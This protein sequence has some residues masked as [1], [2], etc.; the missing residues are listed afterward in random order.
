MEEKVLTK[1]RQHFNEF[2]Q[3]IEYAFILEQA[4]A[5]KLNLLFTGIPENER[6]PD[7]A[8]IRNICSSVLKIN[9]LSIASAQRIGVRSASAGRP[10][11]I[12]ARF[13]SMPDRSR[14][15]QA[16][17]LLQHSPGGKIWMQ[18]DMPKTLK[19]DLR[20][21]LMVAKHAS[22]IDKEEYKSIKV[23]DFCLH[24][25]GK[26]YCPVELE[27]LPYGS[28]PSTFC[29]TWSD[30][31][32]AFFGRFSPLSNPHMSPFIINDTKFQSVEQ[33]LAVARARLSGDAELL[34]RALSCS[35]PADCKGI[36]NALRDDHTQEWEE[37]RAP[38][39]MK[40]LRGKFNQN[41]HLGT[42]LKNTY[43]RRLGEASRDIVWGIGLELKDR[44][45]TQHSAWHPGG[46]L[47]GRLLMTVRDELM[48]NSDPT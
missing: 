41:G 21:L 44:D 3:Q 12:L 10:R 5:R 37:S 14:V 30:E 18:E 28:H 11:P 15:W 33:F 16:K 26:S 40:A 7:I 27:T 34:E 47:L 2:S 9:K 6:V 43:P 39:L 19:E 45:V 42:Y 22:T 48:R 35:N 31:A 25:N 1:T 38:V 20:V 36:L 17:N 8:K 46:N 29:T 13:G 24:Y 32:V 4:A 23:R